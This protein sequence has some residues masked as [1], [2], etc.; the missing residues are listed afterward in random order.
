MA[1]NNKNNKA[2]DAV[3][4]LQKNF[5]EASEFLSNLSEDATQEQRDEAT[6]AL[7]SAKELLDQA[8]LDLKP[9]STEAKEKKLKIKFTVTPAGKFLLPYHVDQVVSLN[10]NQATAIIEAGYAELVK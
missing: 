3:A 6:E 2:A 4:L 5:D 8:I 9:K 7:N 10:E 1:N